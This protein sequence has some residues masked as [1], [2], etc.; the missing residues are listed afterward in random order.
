M[1]VK[2]LKVYRQV[3]HVP[4]AL[5]HEDAESRGHGGEFRFNTLA[6]SVLICLCRAGHEEHGMRKGLRVF[7]P[8]HAPCFGAAG[9]AFQLTILRLRHILQ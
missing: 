5:K 9:T 1:E 7:V 8:Q 6:R 3:H 4:A 2:V